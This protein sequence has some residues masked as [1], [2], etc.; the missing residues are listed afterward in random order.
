MMGTSM[1]DHAYQYS[2]W[3]S[4]CDSDWSLAA[5]SGPSNDE[6]TYFKGKLV[7]PD[8]TA[9]LLLVL[10]HVVRTHFF[11]ARPPQMDPIVTSSPRMVR[12]E[13][14]SGCCGVYARVDLDE[15]AFEDA[16]QTFGTTNVDFN[17]P[18]IARL[19]R[20][21]EK[22]DVS[23]SVTRDTV[24]IETDKQRI[25][26]KKVMLPKRWIKGLSEVQ[27]YQ[28]RM[29]RKHSFRPAMLASLLH[30]LHRAA[31][32]TQHLVV[33]GRS[34]RLSPRSQSGAMPIGGAERLQVITPLLPIA[35]EIS[36]WSDADSGASAVQVDTVIGRLWIVLSPET[37]RGFSGEGQVL[38]SLADQNWHSVVDDLYDFLGWQSELI[39]MEL[40]ARLGCSVQQ[41]SDSLAA[42][43]TRGLAG[44]DSYSGYFFHRE[45]PFDVDS[46]EK[47]QPRLKAARKLLQ[48]DCVKVIRHENTEYDL[49]ISGTQ[50]N[51]FVRLREDGD[52][53]SCIWFS[54]HQGERGPCKHVLA[55]R[56]K[57]KCKP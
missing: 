37:Y 11:D 8:L 26:E 15:R 54:R 12:F 41:A 46:I 6:S 31:S 40:A 49:E 47:E 20:I 48:N 34:M 33:R 57:V 21:H 53:C 16:C 43:S 52:R 56:L 7:R 14:F 30:N 51:Q 5:S 35:D 45:L 22:E 13:G 27:A 32:G 29:Q 2:F 36:F 38:E 24:S 3:S 19:S 39:P 9:K 42:L 1:I 10:N 17:S 28:S 55:A 23:L 25:V 18:M 44:F 4:L 50:A